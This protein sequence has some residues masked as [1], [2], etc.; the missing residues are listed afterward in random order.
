[1]TST[2]GLP[3]ARRRHPW[4]PTAPW[5]RMVVRR[6]TLRIT[7]RGRTR[8]CA[9]LTTRPASS[10]TT[11]ARISL[12]PSP[13]FLPKWWRPNMVMRFRWG[14][15]PTCANE[16]VLLNQNL[17]V[18]CVD[19]HNPHSANRVAAFP[20]AP[21]IR[22]S[23]TM[24]AGIS[25]TD[26]K[27]VVSPAVNQ[28]ENCLRC[29][30]T[31]TGKKASINF[32]YLPLRAVAASDPLNVIPE[33]S[34]FGDLQ[35]SGVPRSQQHVPATQPP[36]QHA[37]SR[38]QDDRGAAWAPASCAPTATIATTI[39][40]SAAVDP[41][42]RMDQSFRTSWSAGM[43]SARRALPGKPVTNLFP[44][45]SLKRPGRPQRRPLCSVR[46]VPRPQSDHE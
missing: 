30:G 29:H 19:C 1:M 41:A 27:T 23:Q 35:S 4:D 22:P 28:Y 33:F 37:E 36:C 17:H 14:T 6:A 42:D 9:P 11:A 40:N 12:P 44:N 45:P 32:G 21:A 46:Q 8:C 10:A 7:P 25:A 34:T 15:R 16:A 31:S 20:A 26:G 18:T 39:G 43:S 24:V 38:R 2:G 3:P 5:P 13:M